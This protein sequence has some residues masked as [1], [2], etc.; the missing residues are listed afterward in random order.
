M[1]D[2]GVESFQPLCGLYGIRVHRVRFGS[3]AIRARRVRL[4]SISHGIVREIDYTP[5]T[6]SGAAG[7]DTA[8]GVCLP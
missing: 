2:D 3:V 5:V 6:G 8:R 1:G 4:G 7:S